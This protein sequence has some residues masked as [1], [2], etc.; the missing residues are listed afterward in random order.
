[1]IAWP[2]LMALVVAHA[3]VTADR[4]V[5]CLVRPARSIA[6]A[7]RSPAKAF[8]A[9]YLFNRHLRPL[10]GALAK[11]H[12]SNRIAGAPRTD[13]L[14]QRGGLAASPQLIILLA[15]FDGA[16]CVPSLAFAAISKYQVPAASPAIVY[17]VGVG[18]VIVI[19]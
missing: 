3:S 9:L 16:L 17:V 2:I 7:I 5:V 14:A 11:V 10:G 18:L 19:D 8:T 15:M 13:P 12:P 4:H 1:M 6:T